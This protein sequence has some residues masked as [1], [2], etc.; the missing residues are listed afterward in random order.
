MKAAHLEIWKMHEEFDEP[1]PTQTQESPTHGKATQHKGRKGQAAHAQHK[2]RE[3]TQG[4]KSKKKV[5][6]VVKYGQHEQRQKLLTKQ[7]AL[8][9][10]CTS[11]P[12]SM[13]QNKYFIDMLMTFDPKFVIPGRTQL[14]SEINNL[15]LVMKGNIKAHIDQ[16]RKVSLCADIWSKKG[17][18]SSYLGITAHFFLGKTIVSIVLH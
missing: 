17:L 9:I 18:S 1:I 14:S 2:G 10:G 15:L 11:I 3:G 5:K 7:V 12:N 6:P 4:T 8:C 16:A 13:I